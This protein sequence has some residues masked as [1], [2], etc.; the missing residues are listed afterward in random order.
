[1]ILVRG[2]N[3]IVLFFIFI[4]VGII[5][6]YIIPDLLY[7]ETKES[8]ERFYETIHESYGNNNQ[9]L[10]YICNIKK[11]DGPMIGILE[12]SQKNIKFTPFRKKLL[13]EKVSIDILNNE[14]N[15]ISII[16]NN[17]SLFN[18]LFFK[19]FSQSLRLSFGKSNILIQVPDLQLSAKLIKQK[20]HYQDHI[21]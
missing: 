16:R 19:E 17:W 8:I 1:M 14:I 20:V 15:D 3:S 6:Y 21:T 12:V 13:D 7:Q 9:S 5:K 2:Y 18:I 11:W 10:L 4:G